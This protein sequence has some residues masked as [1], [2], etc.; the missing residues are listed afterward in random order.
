[1]VIAKILNNSSGFFSYLILDKEKLE[2]EGGRDLWGKKPLY[3][4]FDNEKA[5][6]SSEETGIITILNKETKLNKDAIL[7]YSVY[8]NTFFGKTY[9]QNI[10]E[11]P[12]GSTFSLDIKQWSFSINK[13]WD[14]YYSKPL[15]DMI[16][17]NKINHNYKN[18]NK[19]NITDIL[20]N[21]I[22][23]RFQ[24]DVPVQLALSA[25]WIQPQL[26]TSLQLIQI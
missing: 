10:N 5:I 19:T 8:K 3:Y 4:Y 22:I 21:C 14:D 2:I 7:N 23:Q 18:N 15:I 6:F 9:F 20:K 16:D 12:P 11:I 25:G 17:H 26:L 1:M 13:S 24:C